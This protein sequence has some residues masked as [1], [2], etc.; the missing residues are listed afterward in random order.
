[1]TETIGPS[2]AHRTA[3]DV[4]NSRDRCYMLFANQSSWVVSH[5]GRNERCAPGEVVLVDSDGELLT[6]AQ[7]GFQGG[8]I[9]V[10]VDWMRTWLG[11]PEFLVG[12]RI[13]WDSKWGPPF[14]R[15]VSEFTPELAAA[16]PLPPGVLVDQLGAMLALIAGDVEARTQSEL[17]DKVRDCIRQRCSEP[18]LT[19]A[20]IATSLDVPPRVVHRVLA[21][22]N[23]TFASELLDARIRLAR[24]MLVSP[25][26]VELPITEIA[27]QSGFSSA[28]HF[29][30][31]TRRSTGQ[32]PQE[33]RQ[34]THGV[35]SSR[36]SR[37]DTPE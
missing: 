31:A 19:G 32:T 30:R 15:M 27:Q 26:L 18:Q 8:I 37:D 7:S 6:S 12:R 10:P 25:S 34:L 14:L 23:M 13:A 22:S 21:A 11:D 3:R 16:P 9:K 36:V 20:D 35:R 17:R 5:R 29:T 2:D 33:L 4:Q 1:M 24:Q 28:S